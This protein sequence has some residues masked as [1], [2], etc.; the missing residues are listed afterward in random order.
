[1]DIITTIQSLLKLSGSA[2]PVMVALTPNELRLIAA[3]PDMAAELTSRDELI[4]E[5]VEALRIARDW[6]PVLPIEDVGRAACHSVDAAIA[7][8]AH[9]GLRC[10]GEGQR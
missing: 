2:Q 8:A 5:L 3:A 9:C 6:M 7:K 10:S 4:A 1:M